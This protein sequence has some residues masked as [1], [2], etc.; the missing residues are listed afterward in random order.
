M[1]PSDI[2]LNEFTLVI[3]EEWNN[4]RL[5]KRIW[6]KDDQLTDIERSESIEHDKMIGHNEGKESLNLK[7]DVGDQSIKFFEIIR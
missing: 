3:N 7:T 4:F 2:S 6:I 1:I 5:K